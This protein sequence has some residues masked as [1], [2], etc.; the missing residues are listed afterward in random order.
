MR[1]RIANAP[2]SYGIYRPDHPLPPDRLLAAFRDHGYRG[3]DSGPLGYLGEGE[4]LARRLARHDLSLAGG[5]A[6]LRYGAEPAAFAAD[7]RALDR[8]L[9]TFTAVPVD[10]A[11]FAPRPTLACPADPERFAAPG[12]P[13]GPGRLPSDGPDRPDR[14]WEDFAA[15]VQRAADRCRERGLE[16]VFHPHLGT[17]VETPEET[18]RLLSRTDVSLCLDTGHWWLAGGDPVAAV[19]EFGPRIRQVH[20]KDADRAVHAR[21]RRAGGDLWAV[22]AAGGF[23]ALGEG[24]LDL[25]AVLAALREADYGGWLVVEQD[26]SP[27]DQDRKTDP[28]QSRIAAQQKANRA[29]LHRLLHDPPPVG[30]HGTPSEPLLQER[31]HP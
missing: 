16:P 18:R 3:T 29:L 20:L 2:V 12:P 25:P 4:A 5:W 14:E 17:V 26:A 6:D 30:P 23:P 28:D 11:L 22:V 13:Y 31:P 27:Q 7:L 24:D 8:T 21:V 19:A 9:D 15:D 10:D 1:V